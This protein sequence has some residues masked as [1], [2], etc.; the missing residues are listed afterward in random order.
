MSQ[1]I[2]PT[3]VSTPGIFPFPLVKSYPLNSENSTT[4]LDIHGSVMYPGGE[5]DG[6]IIDASTA[7]SASEVARSATEGAATGVWERSP[8][9]FFGV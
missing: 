4:S 7:G 8:Q 9:K 5:T 6:V 2:A 3:G 1:S